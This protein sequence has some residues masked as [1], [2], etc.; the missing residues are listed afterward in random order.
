VRRDAGALHIEAHL[1]SPERARAGA[2]GSISSSTV[3]REDRQL[4]RAVSQAYGSVLE[5][6]RYP[7]GVLYLDCRRSRS[8]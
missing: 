8:T 1:A 7:V 4:A 5:P 3:A 6:G 2:V